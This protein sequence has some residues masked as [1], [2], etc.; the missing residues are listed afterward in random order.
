MITL[1]AYC[2]CAAQMAS[3]QNICILI[4]LTT[5]ALTTTIM[6]Q[7]ALHAQSELT[8]C[9]FPRMREVAQ[10]VELSRTPLYL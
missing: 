9:S 4:S 2:K 5:R 1:L 6:A 7:N 10:A 8:T 3:A